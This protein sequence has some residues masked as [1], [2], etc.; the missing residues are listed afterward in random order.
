MNKKILVR[1]SIIGVVAAI[2]IGGTIAY[3]SDTETS[4]GNVLAA[5][6]LDLK[7]WCP[8]RPVARTE[9][10]NP[11]YGYDTTKPRYHTLTSADLAKLISRDDARYQSDGRWAK[12]FKEYIEFKFPGIPSKTTINNV[13]LNFEWQRTAGTR[14]ARLMVW[15]K[16]YGWRIHS[17]LPLPATTTDR[18]ETISLTYLNTVNK[19]NA[20]K[21]WFQA[22]G[23]ITRHDWVEVKVNYT[24]RVPDWC[25]DGISGTFVVD[26]VKPGDGSSK[27]A[28]VKVKNTGGLDGVL[29][30]QIVN[31][32]DTEEE[33]PESE[34]GN[35]DEPGELSEYILLSF[36]L[37]GGPVV[38]KTIKE[39]KG[40]VY[41]LG[42]LGANKE[43]EV[44]I[45]WKLP[46]DTGNDIQGDKVT[47]NIE[48]VLEQ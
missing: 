31:V 38:T 32:V 21:I 13:V 19:V 10:L 23:G 47:F 41:E 27:P 29:K 1:L 25:D 30:V 3:F 46:G 44:Q 11:N 12:T 36:S 33:N 20:M 16:G 14:D 39:L 9:N 48:F 35:V 17:L 26:G 24:L 18:T 34:T 37:S 45:S 8:S 15:E 42:S 40:T 2:A 22:I 28:I 5:G 43:K 4:A 6:T 7:L